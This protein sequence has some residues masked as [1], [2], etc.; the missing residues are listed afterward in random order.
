METTGSLGFGHSA[1]KASMVPPP[2]PGMTCEGTSNHRAMRI[3]LDTCHDTPH[4][5]ISEKDTS[6]HPTTPL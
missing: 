4:G 3:K 5:P 2:I 6:Q 1:S